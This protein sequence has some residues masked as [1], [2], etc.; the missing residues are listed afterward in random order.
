ML[1]TKTS[2]AIAGA[3]LLLAYRVQAAEEVRQAYIKGLG[4]WIGADDDRH[5]KD[6]VA[7]GLVGFGYALSEHWN[8]EADFQSLSLDGRVRSATAA[9]APSVRPTSARPPFH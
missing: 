4:T 9:R 5:V 6:D 1:R 2:A 8:I 7:G 3:T